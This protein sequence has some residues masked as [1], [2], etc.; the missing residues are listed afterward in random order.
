MTLK[1]YISGPMTGRPELNF[2]AFHAAA[3]A[4]R[5]Q[6]FD[7]VNPAELN[8]DPKAGWHACM[9]Q[10]IKALCDCNLLVLLPGW[11]DSKGAHIELNLAHR[12]GLV[13]RTL[14]DALQDGE[15]MQRFWDCA[16][17]APQP[18]TAKATLIDQRH[19]QRLQT[20][21]NGVTE[22]LAYY[23]AEEKHARNRAAKARAGG[24]LDHERKHAATATAWRRAAL[25]LQKRLAAPF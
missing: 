6:G 7:V 14:T 9:R 22:A 5:A 11:E 24:N 23:R 19:A 18:A 20:V 13:V 10:D 3:A 8:T 4:L 1:A 16:E 25:Q 2:P 17:N 15:S 12:L 21:W